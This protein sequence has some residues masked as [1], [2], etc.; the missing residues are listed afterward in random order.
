MLLFFRFL[1]IMF[2]ARFRSRIGPLDESVVR[3]TA[4][5]HDCDL[6]FHLNAGRT[7]SF[8]DVARIELIGRMRLMGL[9]LR[10]KLRPVGGGTVVRFRR[11]VLPFERFDIRSRVLGWDE[12]WI[13]VEHVVEK[14]G[15][16]CAIG[17]MRTVIRGK[18]GSIPPAEVLALMNLDIESPPLPEFVARWRDLEDQR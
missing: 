2:R 9:L 15:L 4:L 11:S 16:F 7:V 12:K 17:H 6:N 1:F 8:M 13:Y 18:D 3:F 5:P 14:D 10:R